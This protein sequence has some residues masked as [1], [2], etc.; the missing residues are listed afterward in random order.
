MGHP[1][2]TPF[3]YRFCSTAQQRV[4]GEYSVSREVLFLTLVCLF[5]AVHHRK[6]LGPETAF[7][8]PLQDL[9]AG[10]LYLLDLGFK[11][12]NITLIGDSSG[13]HLV[14]GLSRYLSEM[15]SKEVSI[16]MP[17]ALILISVCDRRFFCR[18][19]L[20]YCPAI[21]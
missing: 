7:P 13:G 21:G 15:V 16:G 20:I 12:G 10:Y 14:L 4:L 11:P 1:M 9:L 19:E 18:R 2:G 5:P 3:P 8:A 17:G 6:C